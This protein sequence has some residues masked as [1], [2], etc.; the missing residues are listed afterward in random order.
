[1]GRNL[2]YVLFMIILSA[3]LFDHEFTTMHDA[4]N[5]T[6]LLLFYWRKRP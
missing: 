1:M 2:L 4:N 5:Y 3:S 6:V